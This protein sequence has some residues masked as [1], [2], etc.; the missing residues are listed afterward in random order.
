MSRIS[1]KLRKWTTDVLDVP[2]DIVFDLP[3]LTLIGNRQLYIENH[4][5]VIHFSSEQLILA[6]TEGKLLVAG[7]ELI[8][9][10]ILPEEVFIEGIISDIQYEG[11]G[12][13]G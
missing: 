5:G 12:N 9:R 4:R 8:I 13:I 1:R 2:Q 11:K 3:R 10:A 6:V 7:K